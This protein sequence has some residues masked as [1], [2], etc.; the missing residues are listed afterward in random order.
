MSD[1]YSS[2]TIIFKENVPIESI[3]AYKQAFSLYENVLEVK[4]NVANINETTYK[5]RLKFE[6][7]KDISDMVLNTLK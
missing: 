1:R 4:A 2:L 3:D 7:L 6:L 5:S